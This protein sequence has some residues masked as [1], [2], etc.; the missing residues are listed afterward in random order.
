MYGIKEPVVPALIIRRRFKLWIRGETLSPVK[1]DLRETS[2]IVSKQI[3]A[4]P[5]R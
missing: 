5:K 1:P 2:K 3:A 4:D